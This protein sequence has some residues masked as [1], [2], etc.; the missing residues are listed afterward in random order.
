MTDSRAS[1]YIHEFGNSS[2]EL[3]A[4]SPDQLNSLIND[5]IDDIYDSEI[6][7]ESLE[8]EKISQDRIKQIANNYNEICAYLDGEEE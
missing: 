8:N 3:D 7:E 4:L 2:W 5:Q 6:W 1:D